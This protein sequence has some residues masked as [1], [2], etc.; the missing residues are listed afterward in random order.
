SESHSSESHSSESRGGDGFHGT[1]RKRRHLASLAATALLLVSATA[2]LLILR[3]HNAP[4]PP[5]D[6]LF[7]ACDVGQGDALALAAGPA[8]AVVVDTGP[9]PA[10]ADS[11]L[12]SLGVRKVPLLLLTH[13]HADHVDGVPGVLRDRAVTEI[14][15]TDDPDPPRGAT[16]VATWAHS[17]GI[18]TSQA[19]AG[20]RRE[21]GPLSWDVLWP[22]PSVS[23]QPAKPE[24]S[25]SKSTKSKSHA[26]SHA[27]THGGGEE[28]SGPNNSSVVLAVLIAT[29]DG[30]VRVLLTGDI[31]PPAQQAVLAAH[32]DLAAD[33][34]KVPHH[35]SAHQD[36]DLFAAV[37]PRVAVVSVGAGNTY[38]HP[39][40][41]TL[42]LA[43]GAG[44]RVFR[45]D[46]DGQ[47]VVF[48]TAS[49]LRV[50]TR[51]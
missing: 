34:L 22:D 32:P 6:W 30:P 47:I 38:G 24:K 11:C 12:T 18:P 29:R 21:Y 43:A 3:G 1:S 49:R 13:F 46:R 17:A 19:T 37:H 2:T 26:H 15:T 33:I 35:G 20:E 8:A 23:P 36:P 16:E 7:A 25:R 40:P 39:A 42:D 28:G 51:R 45:T 41:R 27:G 4:W 9:D 48:G 31:E 50:A 14:E 10:K 44:A 5:P